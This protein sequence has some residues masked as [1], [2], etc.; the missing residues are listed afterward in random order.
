MRGIGSEIIV[1]KFA[2]NLLDN[3][4]REQIPPQQA[5]YVIYAKVTASSSIVVLNV[6]STRAR[7]NP[8]L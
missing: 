1:K 8:D 4:G 5:G 6:L 7:T 2:N 3:I